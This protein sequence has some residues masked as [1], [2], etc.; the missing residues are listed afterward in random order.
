MRAL[1]VAV[2]GWLVV[3][4]VAACGAIPEV[5]SATPAP[6]KIHLNPPGQAAE[7]SPSAPITATVKHGRFQAVSLLNPVGEPVPGK[8]AP[9]GKSWTASEALEYDATY[10]WQGNAVGDNGKPTPV[11]GGFSTARPDHTVRATINPADDDEVGIAMPVSL[12]FDE[13]VLDKAAVQRALK[14][15]TSVLVEGAWAWLSDTQVDWRP[16]EYWPPHTEVNV[17]AKLYGVHY[18]EGAYGPDDLTTHFTIGRAQ[19]VKADVNSHRLVVQQ[20]G[21]EVA[22]YPTSYGRESNPQLNTPNGTFMVM[23]K[24][25]VELMSN[26][27]YG[28]TD[29]R[30]TWAV[31]ISNHGEYIH[32]NAENGNIGSANT[33]HGCINLTAADAKA[34]FDSALIGDPVEVAGSEVTMEPGYAVYDWIL[35]WEEW[36]QKSAL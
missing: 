10:T 6:A 3:L 25:P 35:S 14:V 20:D 11:R 15:R 5:E 32:E 24:L 19:V 23:A 36:L 33:T 17:E 26:P 4:L 7:V 18:G 2:T 28:Y 34:Y 30:K 1:W 21:N 29:V 16:K 31:R 9:D 8:L 12:R 22:N 13:P 27:E